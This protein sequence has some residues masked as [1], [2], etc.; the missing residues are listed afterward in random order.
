MLRNF[1]CIMCPRGCELSVEYQED[2]T[3]DHIKVSGNFCPKGKDYAV[4]ELIDPK[5]NIA[6]S[7]LVEGGEL[8]LASVRLTNPIPKDRIF[9]VMEEIRKVKVQAP[10]K[11]GQVVISDVLGL[12]SDVIITKDVLREE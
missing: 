10:V 9:P 5:R 2:K 8:P 4:Q 7:V 11:I 1:T 3:K 6:S 12:G